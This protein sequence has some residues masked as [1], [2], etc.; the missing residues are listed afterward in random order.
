MNQTISEFGFLAT[1]EKTS[2]IYKKL[3]E[4]LDEAK[5]LRMFSEYVNNNNA[6]ELE[7]NNRIANVALIETKEF[8]KRINEKPE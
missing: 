3:R 8:L 7:H 2:L 1:S 4:E 6:Y 5:F